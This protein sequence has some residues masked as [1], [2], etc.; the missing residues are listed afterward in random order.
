MITE[1]IERL[2]ACVNQ[3]EAA[4]AVYRIET[5]I[6]AG[7]KI[8]D[9]PTYDERPPIYIGRID[10]LPD[11]AASIFDHALSR[12][13]VF[14]SVSLHTDQWNWIRW[15]A[16]RRCGIADGQTALA[17][18]LKRNRKDIETLDWLGGVVNPR[19]PVFGFFPTTDA[20]CDF[21]LR[22]FEL[23]TP[24]IEAPRTAPKIVCLCGSTRFSQAFQEA[25]LKETLAGNIVLTIGCDMRSDADLFADKHEYELEAIKATLDELHLRK[26][27]IADEVLI[28]NVGGYI[29][30]STRRELN[31]ARGLGKH[32]R[33]LEE[34]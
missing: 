9:L 29:G 32:I 28:L 22:L 10:E 5:A 19:T 21:L 25:N 16:D 31:Y 3:I 34:E 20:A 26:I 30:Q 15:N 2:T 23:P 24:M 7:I 13:V 27:D 1:S 4:Q 6:E 11:S 18:A 12:G 17:S 14:V 8:K 33:F